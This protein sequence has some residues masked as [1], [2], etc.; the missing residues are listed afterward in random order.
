[1]A[2]AKK[3][4]EPQDF[5]DLPDTPIADD[6]ALKQRILE[7]VGSDDY[8]PMKVK[9]L[10]RALGIARDE[11]GR[12]HDVIKGM[13][14][15]GRL[16]I[17]YG[18]SVTVP[19]AMGQIEGVYRA[20]PRGFGFVIPD[21]PSVHGDLFIPPG[22]SLDAITGDT[23]RTEAV[24]KKKDGRMLLEGRIVEV[25][26][27]ADNRFVGELVAEKGKY[28][29]MPGGN[30]LHA[31]IFLS[32]ISAKGARPGDQV[33]VEIVQYP[34]ATQTAR[35]VILE[36][37][38]KT[39]DPGVDVKS[40][41]WQHHLPE[42]MPEAVHEDA[43]R[44]IKAFDPDTQRADRLDLTGETIVTID[45]VDARDFDD[46]ISL[47]QEPDGTWELG[48]H[49]ADVSFFVRPGGAL[50]DEAKKR[51][52][53]VYFPRYVIPML[54]E[55]LS[56]GVCSLQEGEP[57]L[58][59]S[60][61]IRYD[62][63]G[64]VLGSRF[65]NTIISSAKRLHYVQAQKIID[66]D[67]E[68]CRDVDGKV[69]RLL[70][71]MDSL[72]RIIRQ[73]RLREGML[74]LEMPEVELVLDP[75]NRVIDAK[76]ADNSFTHTIIEMFMV[77]AN[78]AVARLFDG[79][80][81]P[82]LRRIHEDPDAADMQQL[83][84]FLRIMGYKVPGASDRK[85]IQNL[86]D[87][88]RGK[89]E[90][91]AVNISVLRSM[92]K[93]EYSPRRVGHY[94]LASAHY[95]HFTSPIRRYPD[96]TIHRLLDLFLAGQLK[97]KAQ[98][99][100][101]PSEE[102]LVQLG[103]HC[104]YTERRAEAAERELRTLKVLELLSNRVGETVEGV[105]T[106]VASFGVFIEVRQFLV[107]GLVRFNELPD[108]WWEINQKA[109]AAV[110]QRSGRRIAIGNA[111]RAKIVGVDLP[112]RQLNLSMADEDLSTAKGKGKDKKKDRPKANKRRHKTPGKR[113]RR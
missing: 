84:M 12:F 5:D 62:R 100:N 55:I 9:G 34:S 63:S 19:S 76:P 95:T 75:D 83:R 37:L 18:D 78:E 60:A 102:D 24:R 2:A 58:T 97:S 108:D 4:D 48:V 80:D 26:H 90:S 111:V 28:F 57:R 113:R 74:V 7:Y 3:N 99:R 94:A 103:K 85:T 107:E 47:T 35:G 68:A 73:R 31:P 87:Q 104:S 42:V 43:R 89:P 52:N 77:E 32:D 16:V 53:S 39:G 64:Q 44:A 36:V 33:V 30:S 10:A 8:R 15:A 112:A 82:A 14:K 41:I 13:M 66:G 91:Y 49:I 21:D 11:Y 71:D 109:G 101:A 59:K 50:D 22:A 65:A 6:L 98:R 106:G 93:A 105:V 25:V 88:V 56:N 20:N 54:P 96:L 67:A 23:V 86:L 81:V 72:S 69:L 29:V 27:R 61:F 46:A 1:M 70:R 45:P 17:G 92:Q 40:I 38:G 51:G 79:L 110:G